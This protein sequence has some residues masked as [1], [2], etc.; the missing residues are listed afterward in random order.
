MHNRYVTCTRDRFIQVLDIQLKRLHCLHTRSALRLIGVSE[1]VIFFRCQSTSQIH[2]YDWKL[3]HIGCFG[4]SADMSAPF[5]VSAHVKQL[6]CHATKYYWIDHRHLHVMDAV[7]GFMVASYE[8][9]P[10]QLEIDP[11]TG[12]KALL[13]GGASELLHFD[14]LDAFEGQEALDML[15]TEAEHLCFFVDTNGQP[16]FYDKAKK[17]FFIFNK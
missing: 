9:F 15:R 16:N 7:N 10:D 11:S 3:K 14:E 8:C 2:K 13:V 5:Y 17:K 1:Q 4:Q 12:K 6:R